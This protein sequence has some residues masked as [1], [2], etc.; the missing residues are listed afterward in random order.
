MKK[1]L[2]KILATTLAVIILGFDLLSGP[3]EW[4][5]L[6]DLPCMDFGNGQRLIIKTRTTPYG[7]VFSVFCILFLQFHYPF[8]AEN[9]Q[10]YNNKKIPILK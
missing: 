8:Y 5:G 4:F 10:V 6:A 9:K 2:R 3:L 1:Q 7:A